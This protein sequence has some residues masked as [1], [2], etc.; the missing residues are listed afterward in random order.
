MRIMTLM[1]HMFPQVLHRSNKVRLYTA[2]SMVYNFSCC[3]LADNPHCLE[4]L[5]LDYSN[6]AITVEGA[7]R[8]SSDYANIMIKFGFLTHLVKAFYKCM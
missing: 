7:L 4:A 5:Y 8:F 1:Q 6:M 2:T 3:L